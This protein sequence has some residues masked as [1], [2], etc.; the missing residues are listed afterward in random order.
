[1]K[2][3]PAT[4]CAGPAPLPLDQQVKTRGETLDASE[5]PPQCERNTTQWLYEIS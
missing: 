5:T 1:M 2:I 4:G 3:G